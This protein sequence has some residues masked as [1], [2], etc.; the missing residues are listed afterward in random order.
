MKR[1]Y[2][3]SILLT[4]Y[5]AR[6]G[7]LAGL[8]IDDVCRVV[9]LNPEWFNDLDAR[10]P[11]NIHH[12][13]LAEIA[14][15]M[16][17]ETFW[18]RKMNPDGLSRENASWYYFMNA[19]NVKEAWARSAR[20]YPFL[21]DV[22][23]P[24]HIQE[25]RH[26]LVRL[27]L[28]VPYEKRI[29]YQIDW[30][31]TQFHGTLQH[32]TGHKARLQE[33]R[34]SDKSP[35]R[36]KAYE[37]FFQVP[38]VSGHPHNEL[39]F[40]PDVLNLPNAQGEGDRNLDILLERIINPVLAEVA[41]RINIDEL[42]FV[43]IQQRL[44]DGQPTIED[45]AGQLGVS[46]RTLQRQLAENKKTFSEIVREVRK[47]LAELYLKQK[48]LNVTDVAMMLGYQDVATFTTAFRKWCGVS[49]SEFRRRARL[50]DPTGHI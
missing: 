27:S 39:A 44:V 31:L 35:A 43:A 3:N 48:N 34:I 20:I 4:A 23:Y 6:E 49:P 36:I 24:E 28:R 37:Q 13:L 22:H 29:I 9:G 16:G 40:H 5:A 33:V 42:V 15:R 8:D 41:S 2:T 47:D 17:D 26:H 11:G 46:A 10:V 14:T 19:P 32:F 1:V 25:D 7:A 38:I 50:G 12:A 21:S 30:A 18:V 45:V